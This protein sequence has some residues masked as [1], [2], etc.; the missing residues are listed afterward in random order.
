MSQKIYFYKGQMFKSKPIKIGTK[1]NYR[2]ANYNQYLIGS[3]TIVNVTSSYL[4]R[5]PM[6]DI[7]TIDK[8]IISKCVAPNCR[9]FATERIKNESSNNQCK[10]RVARYGCYDRTPYQATKH[11]PKVT[12]Q[13][14]RCFYFAKANPDKLLFSTVKAIGNK[15]LELENGIKFSKLTGRSLDNNYQIHGITKPRPISGRTKGKQ[16]ETKF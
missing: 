15:T 6:Y 9:I 7:L 4:T 5:E 11:L 13:G 14:S 12:Y 8:T 2:L 16:N 10:I 1:I 3:G